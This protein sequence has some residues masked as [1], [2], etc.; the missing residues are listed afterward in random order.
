MCLRD[1]YSES[2]CVYV[3]IPFQKNQDVYKIFYSISQRCMVESKNSRSR[4]IPH[5]ANVVRFSVDA[6]MF[7]EISSQVSAYTEW[8]W[9]FVVLFS[10]SL[11]QST[12]TITKLL[13][14]SNLLQ[15][16]YLYQLFMHC[17]MSVGSTTPSPAAKSC[18]YDNKRKRFHFVFS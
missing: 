11:T 2:F 17:R 1:N 5:K 4:F 7:T 9:S 15:S 13:I 3:Q 6:F 16:Y 12:W 8:K 14:I 18:N 10:C